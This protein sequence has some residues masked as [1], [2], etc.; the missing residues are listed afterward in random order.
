MAME[1]EPSEDSPAWTTAQSY[2]GLSRHTMILEGK[3]EN[4]ET[5]HLVERTT[6]E[7]RRDGDTLRVTLLRHGKATVISE[8]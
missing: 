3:A 8:V 7:L 4:A 6:V 2:L 5:M 1:D